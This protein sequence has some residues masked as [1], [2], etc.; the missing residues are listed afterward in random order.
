M[1]REF[2]GSRIAKKVIS[3]LYL[4][5]CLTGLTV[6]VVTVSISYFGYETQTKLNIRV[7]YDLIAPDLT[8]C[9]KFRDMQTSSMTIREALFSS[10]NATTSPYI[11]SKCMTRSNHSYNY[12]ILDARSCL[13]IFSVSKSVYLEYVCYRI[14]MKS[15]QQFRDLRK[16]MYSRHWS[17]MMLMFYID[18][19]FMKSVK[20]M[21]LLIHDRADTPYITSSYCMTF[22]V[23]DP[24]HSTFKSSYTMYQIQ[25]LASP[26]TSHCRNY[27]A[28]SGNRFMTRESCIQE[29]LMRRVIPKT[30]LAPFSSFVSEP[31][32]IR[33]ITMND[34]KQNASISQTLVRLES[35]CEGECSQLDCDVDFLITH[36][37]SLLEQESKMIVFTPNSPDILVHEEIA[38][39]LVDF[40]IFIASCFGSWLGLSFLHFNPIDVYE[41]IIQI[42]RIMRQD[43]RN[44]LRR[45]HRKQHDLVTSPPHGTAFTR[46]SLFN[47]RRVASPPRP[48]K[49]YCRD[50]VSFV[51]HKCRRQMNDLR[52]QIN[53]LT[54]SMNRCNILS[55]L[56][57]KEII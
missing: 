44:L 2:A 9:V 56:P 14:S 17:R 8:M 12:E 25:R 11:I 3:R 34:V 13:D 45:N 41:H 27:T 48:C 35:E 20:L 1:V 6:Q 23:Q 33:Q 15:R 19:G 21:K 30:G 55:S 4:M 31:L 29:C 5:A 42:A 24:N 52:M 49:E 50:L 38:F 7:S 57:D 10:R 22:E 54:M 26:Y 32:P 16:V 28:D 51:D 53:L 47:T 46:R 18:F 40:L 43:E 37:E 39:R 36:S